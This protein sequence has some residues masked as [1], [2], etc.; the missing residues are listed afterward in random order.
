[1]HPSARTALLVAGLAAVTSACSLAKPPEAPAPL[2][3]ADAEVI[4]ENTQATWNSG[5]T[6]KIM[7]QYKPGAVMF[8][9]AA[10]APSDDRATQTKW[11]DSFVAMKPSN[12]RVPDRRVQVLDADTIVMSG[13]GTF[14]T[15]APG[16]PTTVTMRYSDV[17]EKQ[18]DGTW[19]IVHEHLSEVP[20]GTS[21]P[22]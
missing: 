8:D 12:F 16:G 2:T 13:T 15:A 9:I 19:L 22:A 5:D 14:D 1:M 6:A 17:L 21:P 20:K 3:Q 10:P 4:A 7:A 11:T 18:A